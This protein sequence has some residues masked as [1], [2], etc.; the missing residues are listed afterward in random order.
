MLNAARAAALAGLLWCLGAAPAQATP[1]LTA[2]LKTQLL[3]WLGRVDVRLDSLFVKK[4]GDTAANFHAAVDGKGATVSLLRAR[5]SDGNVWLIGGYNPQSWNVVDGDHVTVPEE[6]RTAF[7]FNATAGHVY[8]QVPTPPDQGIPDYGA[9]QT[10]NCLQ[11]GPAFGSGADLLVTND[12]TTG[13]SSLLTS[14]YSFEPGAEPFGSS[15]AGTGQFTYTAMEVYAVRPVPE[16]D[17]LAL[18]VAGLSV[19]AYAC[20]KPD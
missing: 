16:P 20:R 7:I 6:E 4:D 19:L 14:Y 15:L 1:I 8:R 11:C 5:D 2:E 9:H 3:G 18:V 12:L 17:T 13:G 10:Y